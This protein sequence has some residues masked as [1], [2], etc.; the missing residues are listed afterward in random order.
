MIK[1]EEVVLAV[2]ESHKYI[3]TKENEIAFFDTEK[4][5]E[6]YAAKMNKINSDYEYTVRNKST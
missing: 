1:N 2:I 5:A 4:E 6:D 3:G